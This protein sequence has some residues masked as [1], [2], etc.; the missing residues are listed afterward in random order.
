MMP[1]RTP[2]DRLAADY[3][4]RRSNHEQEREIAVLPDLEPL[5]LGLGH[6]PFGCP[7]EI[8]KM[9]QSPQFAS[10][11]SDTIQVYPEDRW[12][13]RPA[14][15]VRDRF[16]LAPEVHVSFASG[17]SYRI[18]HSILTTL[19]DWDPKKKAGVI[20]VAPHFP[21]IATLTDMANPNNHNGPAYQS[22]APPIGTPFHERLA[23]LRQ[24]RL[25]DDRPKI[26]FVD[27]PCNPTGEVASLEK[28]ELLL[29]ATNRDDTTDI[30]I[31]DEAYGDALP[32]N[33]SAAQLCQRYP[34]LV[35][36]RGLSKGLGL[37]DIRL[38]YAI[39]SPGTLTEIWRNSMDLV[40]DVGGIPQLLA[41]IALRPEVA[42]PFLAEIRE[43]TIAIKMHLI[44]G[45]SSLGIDILP[46]DKR[47]PIMLVRAPNCLNFSHF[48]TR[49]GIAAE[50]GADFADVH[51]E[52]NNSMARL[53]IPGTI[54]EVD[55]AIR[56]IGALL[57]EAALD[58]E[59][60]FAK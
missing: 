46:T 35:V 27:N 28:L 21:N 49:H 12:S 43:K 33:E 24:N 30:A 52:M 37:P 16:N 40:F 11:Y 42:D 45:L 20:A 31:I 60:C 58:P 6:S 50:S 23:L 5:D 18:L 29:E 4:G 59:A 13:S 17:G 3:A 44:H 10:L 48:L 39:I 15:Q 8:L 41:S 34:N 47:V 7:S 53:R 22:I 9:V 55:E 1:I 32:C 36:V 14:D 19:T 51:P 57:R 54:E 25:N 2:P 56:R 38:G 26:V